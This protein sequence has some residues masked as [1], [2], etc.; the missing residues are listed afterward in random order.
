MQDGAS[1]HT[2]HAVGKY[3]DRKAVLY[4]KNWP[5]YSPDLNPIEELWAE[6]DSDIQNGLALYMTRRR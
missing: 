5:A 4:L 6:L 1:C 2:A 3:L